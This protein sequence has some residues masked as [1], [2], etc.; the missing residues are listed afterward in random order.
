MV[1]MSDEVN[2]TSNIEALKNNI[3]GLMVRKL[4]VK[5]KNLSILYIPEITNRNDLSDNIIKPLVQYGGEQE[6]TADLILNS[7]IYID[8]VFLETDVNKMTDY[9]ME[10]KSLIIISDAKEYIVTNT[11]KV[12]KRGI[13]SPEVEASVRSP[14]DAF[15]ENL[16]S[17]LSLIRYRIKDSSLKTEY[18]TVGLRTKTSVVLVYLKDVANSNLIKDIKK[19]LGEIKVD[20]ILESGYIQ[21]YLS[22][23]TSNLFSQI[24]ISERSDSACA[25][26][27]EGRVC[28]LVEGSNLALIAPKTFVSFLDAGDDH[29]DNTYVGRFLKFLRFLALMITLTL[30]S[31]YVTVVAFHPEILPSLYILAIAS[32]RVQVPVNAVTEALLMELVIELLREAN[33][34]L[35]KQ[36]G[37]SISIVGTIVIGQAAVIAGLVSPLMVIIVALSAMASY[38]VTDYTIMN[39]IRM[40]KFL[41][42]FLASIFGLF[43]FIMGLSIVLIKIASIENFGVP[44]TSPVAP[45]KFTDMKNYISSN[46]VRTKKRPDILD[47][48]DDRRQK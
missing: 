33:L 29:Y 11:F 28:I 6:L 44:Y 35:P 37:S 3:T 25:N 36:I 22:N 1:I 42:I 23:K 19:K 31:L 45:F 26:I 43:G 5:E 34:R 48:K 13:E 32:S 2:H 21:K 40:L 12:E 46:I 27:L 38:A 8:E 41:M 20:G 7:I 4:V 14:R 9:I 10:G 39:P 47:T 30:S 15:V 18:C 24:G 16:N 17:N